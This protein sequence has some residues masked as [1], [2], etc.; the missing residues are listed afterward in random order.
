MFNM[1]SPEWQV[2]KAGFGAGRRRTT[3][4]IQR[5]PPTAATKAD[6]YSMALG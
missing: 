5:D 2:A 6:Q 3:D 1:I 4:A